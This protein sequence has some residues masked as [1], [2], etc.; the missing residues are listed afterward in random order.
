MAKQDIVRVTENHK[1]SGGSLP[2]AIPLRG[3]G[4][5]EKELKD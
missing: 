3:K 4:C 2:R 5:G 1:I